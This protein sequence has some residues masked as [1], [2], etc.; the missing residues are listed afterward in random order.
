MSQTQTTSAHE[1]CWTLV[2]V[3]I[4]VLMQA[5]VKYLDNVSDED[6]PSLEI[7]TGVPLIYE[8]DDDLKPIRHYY[9][10]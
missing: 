5:L 6:I 10:G 8:L 3:D 9:V 1:L 7:P 2:S 4:V